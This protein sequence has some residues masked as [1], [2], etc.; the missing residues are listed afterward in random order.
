LAVWLPGE[1]EKRTDAF[2][3]PSSP[4]YQQAPGR[5]MPGTTWPG[6][7]GIDSPDSRHEELQAEM[8]TDGN[9]T[10]RM[11]AAFS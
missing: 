10:A 9:L 3:P 8:R 4:S 11:L 5:K 6:W 2:P 1:N 7:T